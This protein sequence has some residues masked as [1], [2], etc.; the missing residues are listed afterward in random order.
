LTK[1]CE[2]SGF[3][4]LSVWLSIDQADTD[5][6]AAVYEVGGDG[7]GI[8]L[9]N[10]VMRA[11]Y[12]ESFREAKLIDT[13]EPLRYDFER[14]LFVSREVRKGSRLRLVIGAL[15]SIYSQRN[16]NTGSDVSTESMSAAQ[17]VTV[18]LFHNKIY[19]SALYIPFGQ[20]EGRE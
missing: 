8:L 18:K 2:I 15:N 9:T 11:R 14:F 10:D 4:K 16:Y 1:D 12:R 3:F 7:R 17:V 20:P 6:R 5:F 13:K 19:P